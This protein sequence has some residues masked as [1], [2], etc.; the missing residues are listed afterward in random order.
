MVEY[1]PQAM[2]EL[3]TAVARIPGASVYSTPGKPYL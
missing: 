1:E 2:R 3:N